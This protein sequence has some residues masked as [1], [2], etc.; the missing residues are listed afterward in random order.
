MT[1]NQ[2]KL[3]TLF[4]IILI[5]QAFLT[6]FARPLPADPAPPPLLARVT[7]DDAA[8]HGRTV[9]YRV[10]ALSGATL[11]SG[12][13][14][15]G[16]GAAAAFTCSLPALPADGR[17][18][19]VLADLLLAR[20]EY[21][22]PGGP[23]KT[24]E[25]EGALPVFS[26]QY[27][28]VDAVEAGSRFTVRFTAVRPGSGAP[29]AGVKIVI[30]GL[31]DGLSSGKML[32]Y[33]DAQ[34]AAAFTLRA[35]S[36]AE[37]TQSIMLRAEKDGWVYADQVTFGIGRE[38]RAFL[39]T[40]KPLYQPSQTVHIRALV[41]K[42]F[43]KK[44]DAG[45]PVTVLVSDPKDNKVFRK[46][47]KANPYGAVWTD[48][49]LA[50][51]VILG[52]YKITL[53]DTAGT[54]FAERTVE[55]SRYVLPKFKLTLTPDRSFYKPGERARLT[56]SARYFFGKPVA[57]G[58]VKVTVSQF[59]D[60][61][62]PFGEHEVKLDARGEG[63]LE[64]TL[65]NRF[66]GTP[67][68]Q[69]KAFVLWE[70]SAED[71]AGQQVQ[72]TL[73]TPVV[74][75]PVAIH[76]ITEAG[77]AGS[78][79]GLSNRL[80]F[81]LN[82]PLGGPL[83]LPVRITFEQDGRTRQASVQSNPYGVAAWE[84]PVL[85]ANP[86]TLTLRTQAGDGTPVVKTF[87][88]TAEG[89]AEAIV[90]RT[91][92]A[93]VR[94]GETL[95]AF[96]LASK[97][98]G[99]AYW[100][101]LKDGQVMLAG[102]GKLKD[103]RF[104]FSFPSS[105]DF[106]G[107]CLL[108]AYTYDAKG[109][110]LH[111]QAPF[112]VAPPSDLTVNA[113][114]D[115]PEYRPG[116]T[117]T[118]L[119]SL[120]DGH[121]APKRGA[122][123][124]FIVD[125]AVFALADLHPGLEKIY[126]LLEEEI[127]KPR[128]E[129]HGMG[130][131][132]TALEVFESGE[133]R[134]QAQEALKAV[135]QL[136]QT[137]APG[138]ANSYDR[139]MPALRSLA[140]NK[141]YQH[142]YAVGM[143]I[144]RALQSYTRLEGRCPSP[145]RAIR[146]LLRKKLITT[147][148]AKDRWGGEWVLQAW[149][150][151]DWCSQGFTLTSKGPDGKANTGDERAWYLYD[152]KRMR[153]DK[154][155]KDEEG[156]AVGGAM[157]FDQ[158]M[159]MAVP[160]MAKSA[161]MEASVDW[162]GDA[163]EKKNDGG[164]SAEPRVRRSFPETM[165]YLPFIETGTDGRASVEIPLAD[166]ITTWRSV[167]FAS[168]ADGLLGSATVPLKVFQPFFVDLD[169]PLYLTKG[170]EV[171]LPVVVYNYTQD[172]RDVRLV[173]SD[174]EGLASLGEKEKVVTLVSGQVLRFYFPVRA[175]S[176]GTGRILL[177][178]YSGEVSDAIEKVV[179]VIPN[180][181][182]IRT[183]KSGVLSG[184]V[185]VNA[186][187][188]DHA[189]TEGARLQVLLFPSYFSQAIDGLDKIFRMPGGCFEQTS[190]STYPNVLALQYLEKSRK[191]N[192][193]LSM[194]AEGFINHGYQRLLTF[195]V[196]GGGFS[197]FGNPPAN[198]VLTAYGLMEF[199]DMAKVHA[200]DPRLIER[201]AA[202]LASKQSGDG[203]WNADTEYIAEGAVNRFLTDPVRITGYIAWSLVASDSNGPAVDK[204]LG[205]IGPRIDKV[206]DPYTLAL[207][208]NLYADR[209]DKATAGR[210]ASKLASMAVRDG[211]KIT[212]KEAGPSPFYSTGEAGSVEITGLAA[213]GFMKL[214]QRPDLVQGAME[215]L[216]G[217]KDSWGTWWSTQSTVAAL[218]ALIF[219]LEHGAQPFAGT[220]RIIVDNELAKTLTI[221][222]EQSDLTFSWST[223]ENLSPNTKVR[224]EF[225]GQG[226]P[227]Y[228]IVTSAWVPWAF[229]PRGEEPVKISVAYD[230]TRLA[231]DDTLTAKVKVENTTADGLKMLIVDL[232]VPPGFNPATEDLDA[233][234][235]KGSI[236]KYQLTGRQII[237]YLDGLA[238]HRTLTLTYKLEARYPVKV[239]GAEARV[240]EYYNPQNE[241][242]IQQESLVVSE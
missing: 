78:K 59:I 223:V 157:A 86:C 239:Q 212:W 165:F 227:L 35:S 87:S 120:T 76:L 237:L 140:E 61:L 89:G 113:S 231:A 220:V 226:S 207:L 46:E 8:L 22:L 111:H 41:F 73:S 102:M 107:N 137:S 164:P 51:E 152:E 103:G 85:T 57:G 16:T 240:Y 6:A 10:T 182:E 20:V 238:A 205:F 9:S 173:L 65:P 42:A 126:F 150:Q 131:Q 97:R 33:T 190:S 179:P 90:V 139:Q 146:E 88:L 11:A 129:V 160:A 83:A 202:W 66:Y 204:A 230:R 105:P 31:S 229:A 203:S 145:E 119:I 114:F 174:L 12:M 96:I 98:E 224:L 218:K 116:G 149:G 77:P 71:T 127:M 211:K 19:D 1:R 177:K 221:T 74:P 60:S 68:D 143:K 214:Q 118:A 32:A 3:G 134:G 136:A 216:I 128:Y 138:F 196:P 106:V 168:T 37:G 95:S 162:Q 26:L 236:Q 151:N 5:I 36:K 210:I 191:T 29:I 13:A 117:A 94:A 234:K 217:S 27:P 188:P 84:T 63:T 232:G 70:A 213:M 34:G 75:D 219:A 147:E 199:S 130:L 198:K 225:D 228:Q 121:G 159:P 53:L 197:W 132:E 55:V 15:V 170:D 124:A 91:T 242:R 24:A 194:K 56:V 235:A 4:G 183:T 185:E 193:E 148:E 161:V 144:Q 110:L 156:F 82:D 69:G 141:Y 99:T 187:L 80:Y 176:V 206:E 18:E 155:Q 7:V 2:R 43:Q 93:Q 21:G 50:D 171:H 186:G 233:L 158:A 122:L 200:V 169:L 72:A 163:K 44:P 201:T 209:K 79:P 92:E 222:K 153:R 23:M 104:H 123:G 62:V 64:A 215:Y 115:K 135:L 14:R 195:E 184:P 39:Q 142:A 178:A 181:K 167:W 192:P 17:R 208:V 45:R 48:F 54:A 58:T 67:F 108:R 133:K 125:E 47:L 49:S 175:S 38:A 109:N 25:L 189:L 241:T 28:A 40:D 154:G 180:G 100:D 166:S 81:I 101:L 112:I 172:T 30:E 52:T